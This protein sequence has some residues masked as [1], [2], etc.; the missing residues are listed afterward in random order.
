METPLPLFALR[1][2]AKLSVIYATD[3]LTL[4]QHGKTEETRLVSRRFNAIHSEAK[5]NAKM[6]RRRFSALTI[7][8]VSTVR[9]KL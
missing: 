4:L 6:P 2:P 9:R 1:T 5:R 8:V 7:T 3:I